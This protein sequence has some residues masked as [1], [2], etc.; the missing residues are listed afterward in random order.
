[1]SDCRALGCASNGFEFV[2]CQVNCTG[3]IA[4]ECGNGF[5]VSQSAPGSLLEANIAGGNRGNGYQ[6]DQSAGILA[7]ANN[8]HFNEQDGIRV[9]HTEKAD[10]VANMLDNN[11]QSAAEGCGIRLAGTTKGCRLH[12][13]NFQDEQQQPTQ[14]RAIVEE[15]STGNNLIR[16]N[17]TRAKIQA[18][19]QGSTVCDNFTP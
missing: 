11:N 15:P 10:L 3:N 12:Y 1:V 2:Q 16:F 19:G 4:R 14:T 6:I 9:T 8:A 18:D 5:V 13:N 17:L 7:Y